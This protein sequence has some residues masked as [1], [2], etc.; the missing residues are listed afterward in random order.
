MGIM[1]ASR[2]GHEHHRHFWV[3][4]EGDE[5]SWGYERAPQAWWADQE[6]RTSEAYWEWLVQEVEDRWEGDRRKGVEGEWEI[7][8]CTWWN[9]LWS[10]PIELA[11]GCKN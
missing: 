5:A 1:W 2:G 7:G 11:A 6:D 3:G 10:G 4:A 9:N 8:F